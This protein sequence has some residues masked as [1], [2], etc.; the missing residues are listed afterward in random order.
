MPAITFTKLSILCFFYRIFAT[1]R[2]RLWVKVLGITCILWAVACLIA[3]IFRC[4]P[5]KATWDVLIK[6][7]CYNFVLFF[8]II[9][10]INCLQDLIIVLMPLAM[11]RQ[12]QLPLR[13]K[14]MLCFVFLLGGLWVIPLNALLDTSRSLLSNRFSVTITSI[15]RIALTWNPRN[16]QSNIL[17]RP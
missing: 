3:A 16:Q 5:I 15:T 7:R 1:K 8:V 9:E 12:L 4:I 14:V 11:I 17:P 10:P 13:H 6:G 2:F